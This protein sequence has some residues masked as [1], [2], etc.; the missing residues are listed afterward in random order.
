M[1]E[2]INGVSEVITKI[3]KL[4]LKCPNK[5][6]QKGGRTNGRYKAWRKAVYTR[7]Y[8]TCQVCG[9]KG[10]LNAH[11]I[12][13]YTRHKTLRYEVSNGI[14][15]CRVCHNKFHE[16]Y[17]KSNFPSIVKL[18]SEGILDLDIKKKQKRIIKLNETN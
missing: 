3:G 11:H 15:L 13:G 6:S 4:H 12:R 8:Y 7:D 14:T 1:S 16:K 2:F 9:S 5:N 17:G 10:Y 18:I